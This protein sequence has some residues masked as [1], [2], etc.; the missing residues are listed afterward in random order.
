MA[1][2]DALDDFS[3]CTKRGSQPL[4]HAECHLLVDRIV[5]R[6]QGAKRLF[7]RTSVRRHH[8]LCAVLRTHMG[9]TVEQL[10]LPSGFG[11]EVHQRLTDI[12]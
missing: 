3:V 7:S 5:L 12:S 2:T 10:G 11:H 8:L 4:Q 9:Q 1:L 6:R